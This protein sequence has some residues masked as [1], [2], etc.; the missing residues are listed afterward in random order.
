MHRMKHQDDTC[1]YGP[2]HVALNAS[3]PPSTPSRAQR[4]LVS[5]SK[6]RSPKSILKQPNPAEIL[7]RGS[8]PSFSVATN[9]R[10]NRITQPILQGRP[11]ADSS[12]LTQSQI[13]HQHLEFSTPICT[14]GPR[15]SRRTVKWLE[16]VKQCTIVNPVGDRKIHRTIKKTR[17][18][19]LNGD[20]EAIEPAPTCTLVPALSHWNPA[21]L[22]S[23]NSDAQ[24][25]A[26]E[27]ADEQPD[28]TWSGVV[29]EDEDEGD[30]FT[31]KPTTTPVETPVLS[32]TATSPIP[33]GKGSL[34]SFYS[35]SMHVENQIEVEDEID[36]ILSPCEELST[37]SYSP[38]SL[39][40]T[41]SLDASSSEESL[42]ASSSEESSDDELPPVRS[43]HLKTSKMG[44]DMMKTRP[45][46]GIGIMDDEK[47]VLYEQVMEEFNLVLE[48]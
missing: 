13:S 10:A 6:S 19:I 33:I 41:S 23:Y 38:E 29:G 14:A 27:Q 36:Y 9:T 16:E 2:F 34:S 37:G 47:R 22:W 3:T 32:S 20:A 30:Y 12:P 39:S 11:L 24:K 25:K 28:W 21:S 42:D 5:K 4:T 18:T 31:S 1:L 48:S 40:S 44:E 26:A 43:A 35:H 45:N 15:Q 7:R 17:S 8:L 46:L